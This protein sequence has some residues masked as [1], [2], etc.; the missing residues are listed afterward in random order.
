M[1]DEPVCALS[2]EDIDEHNAR[3]LAFRAEH[4][5]RIYALTDDECRRV[6]ARWTNPDEHMAANKIALE[7]RDE[8]GMTWP[9]EHAIGIGMTLIH[10][11]LVRLDKYDPD[12]RPRPKPEFICR[13]GDGTLS[14]LPE[15]SRLRVQL[16]DL[17]EDFRPV[18]APRFG[19]EQSDMATAFEVLEKLIR[20]NAGATQTPEITSGHTL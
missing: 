13:L 1:A 15:V 9:E 19:V 10:T 8:L 7:F 4:Y 12:F 3:V 18:H 6:Y 16:G 20:L 14:Y 2:K 17:H 11:V 5:P